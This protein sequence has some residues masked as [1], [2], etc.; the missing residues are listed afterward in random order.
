L[1]DLFGDLS[2][3]TPTQAPTP[4]VNN[5]LLFDA[6]SNTNPTPAPPQP[7]NPYGNFYGQP[8]Q[9]NFLNTTPNL[10]QQQRPSTPTVLPFVQQQRPA[11]PTTVPFVQPQQQNPLS[12]PLLSPVAPPSVTSPFAGLDLLG[13]LSSGAPVKSTKELFNPT[14]PAKTMQQLL[15]EKQVSKQSYI[16]LST[17]LSINII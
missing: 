17:S 5:S 14:A 7:A 1:E 11:T 3:T 15:M 2:L 12:A 6:F 13:S 16:S 9:P 10:L 4:T 8:A